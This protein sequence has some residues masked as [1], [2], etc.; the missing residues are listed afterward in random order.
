MSANILIVEDKKKIARFLEM[1][2]THEGY[3]VGKAFDGIR[4]L[5]MAE[6]GDY[7]LVLLDILL[8]GMSG[9]EVL[10]RLRRCSE[11][12]VILL[13]AKDAVNDKVS[14]L[15]AGADDYITKPFVTEE[16]LARVRAVLRKEKSHP[17]MF[18]AGGLRLDLQSHSVTYDNEP[19]DLTKREYDL[20]YMLMQ[21]KGIVLS[22]ETL[23]TKIWGYDYVGE[24]NVVDVVIRHLR[25]KIDEMYAVK[26]ISTI[27]GV[28]YVIKND[29]PNS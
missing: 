9:M 10:R 23:L 11:T 7:D 8:P 22:R 4:G 1:E 24:T 3:E 25:S 6:S 17:K 12:P 20:L 19:V 13:T 16:L 2:L 5:E 29:K 15:D 21:N 18:R 26:L 27:R 28:G 14:G